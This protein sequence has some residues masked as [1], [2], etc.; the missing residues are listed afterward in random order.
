MRRGVFALAAICGLASGGWAQTV[1]LPQ[2]FVEE[3]GQELFRTCRA[4]VFYHLDGPEDAGSRV[5]RPMAQ[6]LLD[7]INFIMA[8]T[9]FAKPHGPLAE[10]EALLRFTE[11]WFLDFSRTIAAERERLSD[12]ETRDE[13]LLQ[14]VPI[15]WSIARLYVDGLAAWRSAA[16]PTPPVMDPETASER[17]EA[18]ERGLG[19]RE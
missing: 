6:A 11:T 1:P 12:A 2:T 17:R 10:N 14:C 18:I 5:P 15:I 3:E 4:A 16:D 13:V 8:E 7:Q 19:L 9:L